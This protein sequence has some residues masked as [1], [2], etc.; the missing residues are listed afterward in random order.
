MINSK[1]TFVDFMR[2]VGGALSSGI[3]GLGTFGIAGGIAGGVTG[4]IVGMI[5]GGIIGGLEGSIV[6]A[7]EGAKILAAMGATVFGGYGGI[8]FIK[9]GFIDGFNNRFSMKKMIKAMINLRLPEKAGAILELGRESLSQLE[10]NFMISKKRTLYG[11][12]FG[13]GVGLLATVFGVGVGISTILKVTGHLWTMQGMKI[14]TYLPLIMSVT[15]TLGMIGGSLIGGINEKYRI[16]ALEKERN[17]IYKKMLDAGELVMEKGKI[18]ERSVKKDAPKNILTREE[19]DE[20]ITRKSILYGLLGIGGGVLAAN[21]L[22]PVAAGIV[23]RMIHAANGVLY[24]TRMEMFPMLLGVGMVGG[25]SL[26]AKM[27]YDKGE[28]E[29]ERMEKQQISMMD[30]S[31]RLEK[32]EIGRDMKKERDKD[33]EREMEANVWQDVRREREEDQERN[34]MRKEV[35]AMVS[36]NIPKTQNVS[37]EL[38][39]VQNQIVAANNELMSEVEKNRLMDEL[40]NAEEQLRM[41]S[42]EISR[43]KEQLSNINKE[44]EEEKEKLANLTNQIM[45]DKLIKNNNLSKSNMSQDSI[46]SDSIRNGIDKRDR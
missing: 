14:L 17:K 34:D 18:Y 36:A 45:N 26:G 38:R 4:E 13:V 6:G 22:M 41:I 8:S 31:S 21:I 43:K 20:H 15:S 24:A 5:L 25:A 11:A 44:V 40:N 28:V 7:S 30:R 37:Q 39:V 33:L 16:R 10:K 12:V 23:G 19:K 46:V 32:R 35:T 42:S 29:I 1:R 2:G 27:G 3:G 9:E